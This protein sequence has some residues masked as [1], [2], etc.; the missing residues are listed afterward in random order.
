MV[1]NEN[2][3]YNIV[4]QTIQQKPGDKTAMVLMKN[5]C[6]MITKKN[7]GIIDT[8]E[9]C[10][11]VLCCFDYYNDFINEKKLNL[12]IIGETYYNMVVVV[13]NALIGEI[14]NEKESN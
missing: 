4:F 6:N 3:M 10:D 7:Q 12:P 2:D 11:D 9:I 5:S 1:L 14:L 8:Q 13:L